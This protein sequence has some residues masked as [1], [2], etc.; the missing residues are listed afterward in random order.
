MHRDAPIPSYHSKS[1]RKQLRAKEG[2]SG[3]GAEPTSSTRGRV[4]LYTTCYGNRNHP[5]ID[6]DLAGVFE[7]NGIPVALAE[8]EVCCGMPKL[9]LGDLEAVAKAKDVNVPVL[10][11]WVDKGWAAAT[12]STSC[13]IA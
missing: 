4:V 7:H 3:A 11:S 1:A 13:A 9:E 6:V 5:A 8:K 10:A 2:A 12:T